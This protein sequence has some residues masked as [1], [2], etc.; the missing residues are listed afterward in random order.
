[1]PIPRQPVPALDVPLV[2][3]GRWV[4]ADQRPDRFSLVVFYRGVHCPMCRAHVTELDG[5][6][7]EFA[8]V[9]VDRVLAV[10][11]DDE[12]RARRAVE[13]WGISRVPIGYGLSLASMREWGLYVS[14][15]IKEGQPNEFSEPGLFLVRPDGTLYAAVQT[16]MPFLRPHLDEVVET[17][18][19]INE[20]DY[21]AR[22]EL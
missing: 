13:E 12:D 2:G 5:L 1:M 11:G 22:G 16:T 3:G 4:L 21:P 9:G 15:A 10:S 14:K 20:N 7:D 17:V 19:W 8:A 6:I 18:R